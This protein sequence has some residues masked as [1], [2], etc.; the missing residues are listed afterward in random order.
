MKFAKDIRKGEEHKKIP[1]NL[2]EFLKERFSGTSPHITLKERISKL[3]DNGFLTRQEKNIGL[4][5]KG[6]VYCRTKTNGF[7]Y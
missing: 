5:K 7:I 2:E 4:T 3:V 6:I 1:L